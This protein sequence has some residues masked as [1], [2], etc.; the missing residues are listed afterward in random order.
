LAQRAAVSVWVVPVLLLFLAFALRIYQL[1]EKGLWGDEIAQARRS[2]IALAR[3]LD[4]YR[5]P[6]R[7]F[8]QFVLIHLTRL[9]GTSDFWVRLPSAFASVLAV[10]SSYALARR[11]AGEYVAWVAMLFMA[12]APY[13]IWYAQDAR[14][15]GAMTCYAV[16]ALYFFVRLLSQP[17]LKAMAGLV[18]ASTLLLYN[19][20]F[21]FLVLFTLGII[22]LGLLVLD[23]RTRRNPAV[24][25]A[26]PHWFRSFV[27]CMIV[28]VM[29]ALPL[30]PGTAPFVLRSGLRDASVE[31]RNLPPFQLTF[32]FLSELLG[33]F[34]LS[35]GA[36][37]RAWI[38][39][40][41]S[42][43]GLGVLSVRNPR[44]AWVA[45]AW[46]V[47]PLATLA[48]ARPRHEVVPR[49]L[50]FMQPVF[51]LLM[52]QGVV[53][54]GGLAAADTARR[55]GKNPAARRFVL[56]A[57][58]VMGVLLLAGMILPPLDALYRRAKIND[59]RAVAD[60]VRANARGGDF[61]TAERGSW[62]L[63]ALTY[64]WTQEE[65]IRV[66]DESLEQMQQAFARGQ[67]VW[68]LSW[69]GAFDPDWENWARLYLV[70]IEPKVWERPGLDYVPRDEFVFPQSEGQVTI[71]RSPPK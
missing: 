46:L 45:F 35:A 22:A 53:W 21:G 52:A 47:V 17:D 62:G 56:S 5:E 51:L 13:Q 7:F 40:A 39:L 4:E 43:L 31:W 70:P 60:Y 11:M 67:T 48:I 54:I 20:L 44:A 61:I 41:G 58:V 69:R 19:H 30:A 33:Y 59:W 38:S 63:R 71:Y 18:A 16:L 10:A 65:K 64:Y 32:A 50:I 3:I 25:R 66:R 23:W 26:H 6:P 57:A 29:L 34:G 49:Y 28:V 2:S 12:V 9:V 14:M 55:F 24:T 36:D 27:I 8:L 37:W 42:I 15:Y 1:D 68:Y